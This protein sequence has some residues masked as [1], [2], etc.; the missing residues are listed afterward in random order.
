MKNVGKKGEKEEIDGK[1]HKIM[2]ITGYKTYIL[3]L[4]YKHVLYPP[5]SYIL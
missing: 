4:N 1:I 3:F 5:L 2:D